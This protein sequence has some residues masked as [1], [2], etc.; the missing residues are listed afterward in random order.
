MQYTAMGTGLTIL[1]ILIGVIL[2]VMVGIS[3]KKKQISDYQG[4]LWLF[5]AVLIIVLGAIPRI[6]RF[7]ADLLGVWWAPSI[8]LFSA[9]VLIG[10]ICFNHS[11]EISILKAQIAE[12]A[13]QLSLMKAERAEDTKQEED[14]KQ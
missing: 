14:T 4:I 6:V 1:A 13:M 5:A 7:L 10:F 12:L 9:V 8:L 2:I 11:K 3:M